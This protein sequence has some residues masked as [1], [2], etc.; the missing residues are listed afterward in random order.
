MGERARA[1][2]C[3]EER[4][5]SEM[6]NIKGERPT[7]L[8]NKERRTSAGALSPR[9]LT[10]TGYSIHCQGERLSKYVFIK[11]VWLPLAGVLLLC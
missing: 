2:R 6:R 8:M 3:D 5:W 11:L 4:G 1:K 7:G 9:L 10:G